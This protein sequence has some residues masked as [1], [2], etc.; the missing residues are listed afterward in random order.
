MGEFEIVKL[1]EKYVDDVFYIESELIGKC[2]KKSI[3]NS[4]NNDNLNYY[5]L[6]KNQEVVGFFE[7]LILPPEIEL[8]DIAVASKFQGKGYSKLMMN[9]LLSLAKNTSSNTILLEVNSINYKAIGLYEKYGFKK[10][11]ERKNYYGNND[12]ILMRLDID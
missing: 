6:L 10:Y 3:L 12:A 1:T 7:C 8:Y 11:S 9:Y 2:D 4:I 5:V